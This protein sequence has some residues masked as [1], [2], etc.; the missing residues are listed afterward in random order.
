MGRES[1]D[2]FVVRRRGFTKRLAESLREHGW[3]GTILQLKGRLAWHTLRL[4]R[5]VLF[6]RNYVYQYDANSSVPTRPEGLVIAR[7][8]EYSDI[9]T[10]VVHSL[11]RFR[12]DRH[13]ATIGE[14]LSDGAVLWV[15][16]HSGEVVASQ[17][18]RTGEHFVEWFV[19]LEDHDLVVFGSGTSPAARGQGIMPYMMYDHVRQELRGEGRAFVDCRIWN[20][21]AIRCIEKAG[22]RRIATCRPLS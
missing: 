19:S 10:A 11:V 5:R 18:T 2:A 17:F 6:H 7:Y 22:F 16:S 12:G 13:P 14:E 21:P 3:I 8:T 4:T 1:T 15:A 20:K 9:P